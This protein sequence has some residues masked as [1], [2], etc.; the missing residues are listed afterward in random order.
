MS[1]VMQLGNAVGLAMQAACLS[2]DRGPE[3]DWSGYARGYW[4]VFGWIVG[5]IVIS[6]VALMYDLKRGRESAD[7]SEVSAMY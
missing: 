7:K 5:S 6:G 4:A 2:H 1:V 3:L